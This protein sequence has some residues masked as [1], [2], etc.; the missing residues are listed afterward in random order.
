[1]YRH[2]GGNS[3]IRHQPRWINYIIY[4]FTPRL[5]INPRGSG[6]RIHWS[7][8]RPAYLP[9][10]TASHFIIIA[11]RTPNL[12][13]WTNNL[14]AQFRRVVTVY[15]TN[16]FGCLAFGIKPGWSLRN[17]RECH[18]SLEVI[19]TGHKIRLVVQIIAIYDPRISF[20]TTWPEE[21]IVK[22]S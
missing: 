21:M 19:K 6:V 9:D 1:M 15:F 12:I 7:E 5:F 20:D 11:V 18:S 10:N 13:S 3:C 4:S 8:G 14:T 2:C 16:V 17:G 22:C